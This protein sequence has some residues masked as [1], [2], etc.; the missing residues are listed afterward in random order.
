MLVPRAST[1][2]SF[3]RR[4]TRIFQ[5]P[6]IVFKDIP[7]SSTDAEVSIRGGDLEYAARWT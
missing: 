7:L 6:V 5:S 1:F 2:R 3:I 4:H